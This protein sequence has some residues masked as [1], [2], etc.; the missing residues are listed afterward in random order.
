MPRVKKIYRFNKLAGCVK[1][2]KNRKGKRVG[3]YP[4]IQSGMDDWGWMTVC[5]EHDTCVTSYTL[6]DAL[7]LGADH[8]MFCEHC[9]KDEQEEP[10]Q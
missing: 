4:S 9:Q 3:V 10:C 1:Q 2:W 6:K 8:T 7:G 5:E